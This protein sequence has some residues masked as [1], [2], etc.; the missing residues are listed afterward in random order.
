MLIIMSFVVLMRLSVYLHYRI[1]MENVGGLV[2]VSLEV[3]E[4]HKKMM[5]AWFS[6]FGSDVD[7]MAP[8]VRVLST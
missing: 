5:T 3:T 8:G 7:I 6:N 4:I 1:Q 2:R